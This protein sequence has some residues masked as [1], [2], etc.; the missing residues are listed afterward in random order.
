MRKSKYCRVCGK[1]FK[2]VKDY[3]KHRCEVND[4]RI[5]EILFKIKQEELANEN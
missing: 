2:M 1:T 4:E 5:A 3:W